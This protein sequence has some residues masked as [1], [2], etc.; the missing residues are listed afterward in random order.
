[1]ENSW[2]EDVVSCI[3][4]EVKKGAGLNW[5][6]TEKQSGSPT[7]GGRPGTS[8]VKKDGQWVLNG[9]KTFTTLSLTLD[10]MLVT[11]WIEE[12][13]TTVVFLL[14]KDQA[15]VLVEET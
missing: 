9:R 5:E 12:K 11:A 3:A 10:Y 6:A 1:E 7:R 13:Q 8:A 14:H 15:G 2:N 4:E